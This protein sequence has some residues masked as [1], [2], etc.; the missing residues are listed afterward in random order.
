[1]ILQWRSILGRSFLAENIA[2]NPSKA[3]IVEGGYLSLYNI[4]QILLPGQRCC[5]VRNKAEVVWSGI[6]PPH[7]YSHKDGCEALYTEW[8]VN[9]IFRNH[10]ET[11]FISSQDSEQVRNRLPSSASTSTSFLIKSKAE[12]AEPS[13][14]P[15]MGWVWEPDPNEIYKLKQNIW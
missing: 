6:P 1:M 8:N 12:L 4:A 3:G 11:I 9:L 7:K 5:L 13:S 2:R 14:Q 15:R 10:K